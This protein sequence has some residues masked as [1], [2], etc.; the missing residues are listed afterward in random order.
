VP[1]RW[2]AL[3]LPLFVAFWRVFS[4]AL[5]VPP[6]CRR[7]VFSLAPLALRLPDRSSPRPLVRDAMV[8]SS[9]EP[10]RAPTTSLRRRVDHFIISGNR[11][12]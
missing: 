6:P 10:D 4:P 11:G 2:L 7:V 3:W 1:C 5:C 8:L 9:F 12:K